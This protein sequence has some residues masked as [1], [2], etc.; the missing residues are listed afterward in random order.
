[1]LLWFSPAYAQTTPA[2]AVSAARPA[3]AP[4]AKPAPASDEATVPSVTVSAERPTGRIDRQVYDVKSD[5]NSTNGSA[6]DALNNVP[7]VAVDPDGTVSLRGSTNV[8]ILVDGKPSAMLQGDNRGA[9]LNALP[10]DDIESIEV[11]NNPGAQ[12]GNDGGGGPILNLVMRRNKRPGGVGV[13]NANAGS[14]GRY[15]SAVSGSYNEGPWGFQGGINF[16]HDGRDSTSQTERERID[17]VSGVSTRSSQTSSGKGLNDSAGLNGTVSYNI[18]QQDKLVGTWSYNKRS[19]DQHGLDRYL[20]YAPMGGLS[21]APIGTIS[22]DYLRTGL[23]QG[24]SLNYGWGGQFEHKG[25]LDGELL[26][27]DFRVSSTQNDSDSAYANQYSISDRGALDTRSRQSSQ[28]GNRIADFTG[29]YERPL[30]AGSLKLGFKAASNEGNFDTRYLNVDPFTNAEIV[31]PA[32]T[33]MFAVREDNLALYGSYQWRLNESW[34]MLAGLRAEY[35]GNHI[36]QLTQGVAVDNHYLSFIPSLFATYKMANKSNVRLAYA[37]R[38]RRPNVNDL[39]PYV[40]YRDEFNV[41]SGNPNL[42][43]TKIDSVELGYETNLGVLDT[44]VRAYARRESDLISERRYFISE[45]VLLTTREN[46]GSTRSSGLEFT[47]S[48]KILPKLQVNLSG[49]VAFQQQ[50]VDDDLDEDSLRSAASFRIR[51]RFNYQLTD[52][53]Q[54]Q[55]ML[56]RQGKTLFG[57]GY[58]QANTTVN[59]SVRHAITPKLNVVMNVT[60]VFNTNKIETITD[61]ATLQEHSLRRFDGRIVYVGL[62]YR[63]GGITP[64]DRGGRRERGEGPGRRGPPG[65][66][67]G[68]GG[69]GGGGPGGVGGEGF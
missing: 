29:D 61:I 51:G 42:R 64:Q 37:R 18:G 5:V 19:N 62:S 17:P 55:L 26:R 2:P 60:D 12:F 15:N 39:N 23:R 22:S 28:T 48:G 46:G 4:V 41:S 33:N 50:R 20:S 16:R 27:L 30:G 7:S 52:A 10:S 36:D 58:R 13:V 54:L 40:V 49:N 1:M 24:D 6:A 25:D 31:N 66:G 57:Q 45:S 43:P 47:A 53:D 35:T 63:F 38:I 67:G 68:P 65:E 32:R 9:A 14:G 44:A 3:P 34:G 21:S 8:Q 59:F 56:N 11:I 69:P